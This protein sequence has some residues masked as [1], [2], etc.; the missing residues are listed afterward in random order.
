MREEL[1]QKFLE[2]YF[3]HSDFKITPLQQSGSARQNLIVEISDKK[4]I[5][6]FNEKSTKMR[7][8]SI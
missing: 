8:S 7:V 2:D 5:L 1:F 3:G 4:Y 6:T